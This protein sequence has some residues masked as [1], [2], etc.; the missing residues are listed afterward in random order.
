MGITSDSKSILENDKKRLGLTRLTRLTRLGLGLYCQIVLPKQAVPCLQSSCLS[1]HAKGNRHSNRSSRQDTE[2][3]RTPVCASWMHGKL[4]CLVDH[5]GW[6]RSSMVDITSEKK[7]GPEP[8][9]LFCGPRA[10]Q[11]VDDECFAAGQQVD[12]E[13]FAAGHEVD[14]ECFAAGHQVDDECF[15]VFS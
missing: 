1:K 2:C 12:D 6:G 7:H 3:P 15:A 4:R 10:G 13:C 14:D 5:V 9:M 8:T 11:Q